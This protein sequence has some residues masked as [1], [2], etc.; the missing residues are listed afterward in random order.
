[1]KKLIFA[2][3]TVFALI[4]ALTF[5]HTYATPNL[6]RVKIRFNGYNGNISYQTGA[7]DF[8]THN[9]FYHPTHSEDT[10]VTIEGDDAN[11]F[12]LDNG[13]YLDSSY[14]GF[15]RN[16]DGTFTRFGSS[17]AMDFAVVK[18]TDGTL[19]PQ[20]TFDTCNI[21][22]R[23]HGLTAPYMFSAY[24][25]NKGQTTAPSSNRNYFSGSA[26][27]IVTVIKDMNYVIDNGV[28]NVLHIA[29]GTTGGVSDDLFSA[30]TIMVNANGN[31]I[32]ETPDAGYVAKLR[33]KGDLMSGIDNYDHKTPIQKSHSRH[34]Q[35]SGNT[36]DFNVASVSVDPQLLTGIKGLKVRIPYGSNPNHNIDTLTTI[37]VFKDLAN[38]IMWLPPGAAKEKVYV[39]R[40]P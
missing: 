26:D 23:P 35:Y 10:V 4:A 40:V 9:Y 1:M 39:Y 30:F 18:D 33:K 5:S 14:F 11:N 7:P 12:Y 16:A 34:A 29:D 20:F 22:I 38:Y 19:I 28:N 25:L 37:K 15:T 17:S 21:Q 8:N 24:A 36:L 32:S 27:T 31:V 2:I 13:A 3:I 6:Q